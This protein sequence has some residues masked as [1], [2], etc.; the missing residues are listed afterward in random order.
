MTDLELLGLYEPVVCYTNGEMF[1][2]CAVDAY[3]RQCRLWVADSERR[4]TLLVPRGELTT[5]VLATY[6]TVPQD[7]RLFLQF[8]DE[9]LNAIDY[10]R[11]LQ[12]PERPRLPNPNR[13]HLVGLLTRVFDGIFSLALLLRGR[14]PGGTA[15]AAEM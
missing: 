10:Q 13:L 1:F 6:R 3:L 4:T 8:V 11:W 9:P 12:Q 15:A 5:D 2:P 14:V 7:H